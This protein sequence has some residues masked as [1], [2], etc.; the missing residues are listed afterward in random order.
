MKTV[1][2]NYEIRQD[3]DNNRMVLVISAS[4]FQSDENKTIKLGCK[5]KFTEESMSMEELGLLW[6]KKTQD[7]LERELNKYNRITDRIDLEKSKEIYLE[8]KSGYEKFNK[9]ST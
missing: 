2:L 5:I 9:R 6:I 7:A 3:S 4:E 1:K 8:I